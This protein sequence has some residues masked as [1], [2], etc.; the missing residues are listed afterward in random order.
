MRT[1]FPQMPGP[2]ILLRMRGS[3]AARTVGAVVAAGMVAVGIGL[4]VQGYS[5]YDAILLN[6]HVFRVQPS[7][8]L[9]GSGV[10][11]AGHST[12]EIFGGGLVLGVAVVVALLVAYRKVKLAA[13]ATATVALGLG[14]WLVATG[15]D[16]YDAIRRSGRIIP[17]SGADQYRAIGVHTFAA[18]G[19]V[20]QVVAGAVLLAA[21]IACFVVTIRRTRLAFQPATGR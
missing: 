6:G 12:P 2:G 19:N 11:Q 15:S 21:A 18:G 13:V 14:I 16:T 10:F 8:H 5:T 1:S 4:I 17:V 7:D 20:V 9:S 3:R